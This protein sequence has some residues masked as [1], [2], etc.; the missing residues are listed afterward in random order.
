MINSVV[1]ILPRDFLVGPNVDS[2][3]P[4]SPSYHPW[5][6][7]KAVGK[8]ETEGGREKVRYMDERICMYVRLREKAS[9]RER[10][11]EKN[12]YIHISHTDDPFPHSVRCARTLKPG[13]FKGCRMRIGCVGVW[14]SGLPATWGNAHA[15]SSSLQSDTFQT[16]RQTR[17]ANDRER[18]GGHL[19]KPTYTRYITSTTFFSP[20]IFC[21]SF[22]L[23]LAYCFSHH[24]I[25]IIAIIVIS[26]ITFSHAFCASHHH[27]TKSRRRVSSYHSVIY[28]IVNKCSKRAF[29][30][31][32]STRVFCSHRCRPIE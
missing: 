16:N 1:T 28:K 27:E 13:N 8:I 23:F 21:L 25:I 15:E 4:E 20:Q 7:E 9:E 18:S 30:L 26:I 32:P 17:H 6:E 10:G 12:V 24:F 22:S 19:L 14:A 31:A 29:Y 11:K 3:S 2:S 5:V